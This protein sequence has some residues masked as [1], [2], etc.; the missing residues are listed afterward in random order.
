[1]AS[2]GYGQGDI[3]IH[4][5]IGPLYADAPYEGIKYMTSEDGFP[6]ENLICFDTLTGD[7]HKVYSWQN[8]YY[9]LN[10]F[11]SMLEVDSLWPFQLY[12]K[13]KNGSDTSWVKK[14]PSIAKDYPEHFPPYWVPNFDY[15]PTSEI[16]AGN[17]ISANTSRQDFKRKTEELSYNLNIAGHGVISVFLLVDQYG[18][19]TTSPWFVTKGGYARWT[20][21]GKYLAIVHGGEMDEYENT[22][23]YVSVDIYSVVDNQF[24]FNTM[25]WDGGDFCNA[26]ALSND[27]M[28]ICDHSAYSLVHLPSRTL[29][30]LEG[31]DGK[32]PF[33]MED[34]VTGKLM[35]CEDWS[36]SVE[37]SN[38]SQI[39]GVKISKL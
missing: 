39:K 26:T 22:L 37:L 30:F 27:W 16:P 36:K 9:D 5:E 18:Q 2:V 34:Q 28:F 20:D 13:L 14:L 15:N 6:F 24:I 8:I 21:D 10:P 23:S 4:R 3:P 33:I 11:N 32:G 17:M 19:I 35:Y 38:T 31:F 12:G 29:Y 25:L 7:T 1:M